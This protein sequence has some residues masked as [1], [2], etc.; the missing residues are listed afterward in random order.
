[1]NFFYLI[2][3]FFL[4]FNLIATEKDWDFVIDSSK[5]DITDSNSTDEDT[6]AMLSNRKEDKEDKEEGEDGEMDFSGVKLESDNIDDR[7]EKEEE[8]EIDKEIIEDS[9]KI[10][11]ID[12]KEKIRER[13]LAE[14]KKQTSFLV[15]FALKTQL[16][17]QNFMLFDNIPYQNPIGIEFTTSIL[18]LELKDMNSYIGEVGYRLFYG[19]ELIQAL[20][21]SPL[22]VSFNFKKWK[23][24]FPLKVNLFKIYYFNKIVRGRSGEEIHLF[25]EYI[26]LK[27]SWRF[28]KDDRFSTNLF[29]GFSFGPDDIKSNP[30][31]EAMVFTIGI[32]GEFLPVKIDF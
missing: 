7:L 1:M 21:L 12:L 32:S 26:S 29:F 3:L 16:D 30:K 11:K 20:T 9:E 15:F 27:L 31:R 19:N 24:I 28:F 5:K 18:G 2:L 4:S 10:K 13:E 23:E 6:S 8:D 14:K 17:Y 25:F 22:S